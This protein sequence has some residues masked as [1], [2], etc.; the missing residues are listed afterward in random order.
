MKTIGN[1]NIDGSLRYSSPVMTSA[2][3]Q[4][5]PEMKDDQSRIRYNHAWQ[6]ST[7]LLNK[8]F[9]HINFQIFPKDLSRSYK[10]MLKPGCTSFFHTGYN[11]NHTFKL[12][13]GHIVPG[14]IDISYALVFHNANKHIPD[15]I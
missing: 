7:K 5:Y 2:E 14:L 8:S 1:K 12:F 9:V 15:Y 6:L 10:A 11:I 4:I 13:S 3:W